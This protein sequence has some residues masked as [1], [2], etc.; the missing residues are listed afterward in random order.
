MT[1]DDA[2]KEAQTKADATGFDYGISKNAFGYSV[3]MLPRQENRRGR[4]LT[5]EVV[6][7]MDPAKVQP[8]HGGQGEFCGWH[9]CGC[10]L[11]H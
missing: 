4:E 11:R 6:S 10:S 1:Y 7:C 9:G 8:G 3:F 5:C 2:R